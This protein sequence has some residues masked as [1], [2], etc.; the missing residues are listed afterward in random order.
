MKRQSALSVLLSL[1]LLI[2][3]LPLAALSAAAEYDSGSSFYQ[4]NTAASALRGS[5][6]AALSLGAAA[7]RS[8][9]NT[10]QA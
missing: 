8:G 1:A 10:A 9:A 3:L 2:G 6:P 4:I 5:A 7:L